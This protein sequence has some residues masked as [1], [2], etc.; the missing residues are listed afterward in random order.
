MLK[1]IAEMLDGREYMNE[2][3]QE[4][5][6]IAQDNGIVIVYGGSDDLCIFRGAWD[7]EKGCWYDTFIA[8]DKD[9]VFQ[10]PEGCTCNR[11]EC[12]YL[13]QAENNCTYIKAKWW[14]DEEN[15]HLIPWTYETDIPHETFMIFEADEPYCRG[16]VF[17]AKDVTPK[18]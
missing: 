10:K 6:Q 17:Y 8:I 1:K 11:Y 12:P 5:I 3:T 14:K 18:K 13:K 2:V 15:G 7:D 4:I 9:G 16:I